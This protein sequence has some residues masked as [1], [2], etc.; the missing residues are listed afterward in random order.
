MHGNLP[1][2]V[3]RYICPKIKSIILIFNPVR[4]HGKVEV[5]IWLVLRLVWYSECREGCSWCGDGDVL[6]I[7]VGCALCSLAVLCVCSLAALP[8]F[9]ILSVNRQRACSARE[10]LVAPPVLFIYLAFNARMNERSRVLRY[11]LACPWCN[12]CA[13]RTV[14]LLGP[15]SSHLINYLQLECDEDCRVTSKLVTP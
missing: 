9:W 12:S 14:C 6:K 5:V 3:S 1:N 2:Y 4:K 11:Y 7:I 10:G 8:K 15:S 13:G